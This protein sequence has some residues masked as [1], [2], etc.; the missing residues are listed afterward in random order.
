MVI[1]ISIIL[2]VNFVCK[3]I[4]RLIE[5]LGTPLYESFDTARLGQEKLLRLVSVSPRFLLLLLLL[6]L[7]LSLSF[8]N[9]AESRRRPNHCDRLLP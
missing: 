6:L 3:G 1:N 9:D 8:F 5:T 2:Y 4:T 7:L